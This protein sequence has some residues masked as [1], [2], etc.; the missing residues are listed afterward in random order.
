MERPRVR[1]AG[2]D[3]PVKDAREVR[4]GGGGRKR[5][6]GRRP[7]RLLFVRRGSDE[8]RTRRGHPVRREHAELA[9]AGGG[10]GVHRH[11]YEQALVERRR[12][13]QCVGPDVHGARDD[14]ELLL[15]ERAQDA[16]PA[17]RAP[18]VHA[19]VGI[20]RK[21]RL[22]TVALR[23]G[24]KPLGEVAELAAGR[25][26]EA[27]HELHVDDLHAATRD[28]ARAHAPQELP[29]H[30]EAVRG[31]GLDPAR[32]DV[33]H[34]RIGSLRIRGRRGQEDENRLFHAGTHYA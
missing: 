25:R 33:A 18:F 2:H 23:D 22:R 3:L 14:R 29:A 27:W 8:Q 20:R 31:T 12:H 16:P 32:V 19:R 7:A 6:V 13:L 9:R 10:V 34:V 4:D 30:D 11:G 1:L 21:R 26:R 15:V 24:V 28:G 17:V 5:T